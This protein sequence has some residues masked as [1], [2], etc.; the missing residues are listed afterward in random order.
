M[1]STVL[2]FSLMLFI[3]MLEDEIFVSRILYSSLKHSITP[4]FVQ[5]P[6]TYHLNIVKFRNIVFEIQETYSLYFLFHEG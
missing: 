2:L 6:G 4:R 3:Q 5:V 1:P